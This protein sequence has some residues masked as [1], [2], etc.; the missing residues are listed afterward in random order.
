MIL[1][2]GALILIVLLAAGA[3]AQPRDPE[4]RNCEARAATAWIERALAGSERHSG[5]FTGRAEIEAPALV[6][7]ARLQ[8]ARIGFSLRHRG[9][10]ARR[11]VAFVDVVV[12]NLRS[13]DR[14]GSALMTHRSSPGMHVFLSDVILQPGWPRWDSYETTNYD[15]ITLDAAAALYAQNV[16]ITDWNADAAIDSKAEITQLVDV[17]ITGPGHRPLRFWR[18]GPHHIVHSRIDKPGGG[19]LIWIADCDR[20]QLRIHAS[21]FN[22]ARRLSREQVACDT[23]ET[24]DIIYLSRDPRRAGDMHPMFQI[25]P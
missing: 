14:Y 21:R 1:R 24:P 12:E 22:G 9:S 2:G 6:R 20:T 15:A 10:G 18:A 8:A 16:T 13:D 3:G 17:T 11:A 23:G 5:T 19:T 4:R 7:D 25:C